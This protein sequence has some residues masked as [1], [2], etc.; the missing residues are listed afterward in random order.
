MDIKGRTISGNR[1]IYSSFVSI[2]VFLLSIY[3]HQ[4]YALGV[5][6]E[7]KN[8]FDGIPS[9]VIRDIEAVG[10]AVY[11][12]SENGVFELIGGKAEK[13]NFNDDQLNTGIISDIEYDNEG[14]LWIVEYGVGVFKLNIATRAVEEF[15]KSEGWKRFAWSLSIGE[16]HVA[17]SIISGVYLVDKDTGKTEDWA[18]ELGLGEIDKAYSMTYGESQFYVA[19]NDELIILKM[20][21][22]RIQRLPLQENF[23]LLSSLHHVTKTSD[24]LYLGGKEGIYAVTDDKHA[25]IPFEVEIAKNIHRVYHI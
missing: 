6:L 24:A 17:V 4:A 7:G 21:K 13:L 5:T 14:N 18:G 23:K 1:T 19:V 20:D 10:N 16:T 2:F 22:R 15:I 11:I 9:G 25:F 12:A 3:Q 8:R